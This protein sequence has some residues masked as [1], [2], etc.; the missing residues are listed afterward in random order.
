M[1]ESA[2][3]LVTLCLVLVGTIPTNMAHADDKS[4]LA[5][6]TV[7]QLSVADWSIIEQY[8][9][10][11]K[12][13]SP[14]RNLERETFII[15]TLT[16]K[17]NLVEFEERGEEVWS[18][19]WF[20]EYPSTVALMDFLVVFTNKAN[21]SMSDIKMFLR[22]EKENGDGIEV[23]AP[24]FL[25]GLYHYDVILRTDWVEETPLHEVIRKNK[26]QEYFLIYDLFKKPMDICFYLNVGPLRKAN[27]S[28]IITINKNTIRKLLANGK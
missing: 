24:L 6:M 19:F 28:N 4:V 2:A 22:E 8:R 11:E 20:C 23:V 1:R 26:N 14:T 16:S 18:Q 7:K 21:I 17:T 15:A 13:I 9:G 3:F 25:D 10:I 12:A 27:R 5:D